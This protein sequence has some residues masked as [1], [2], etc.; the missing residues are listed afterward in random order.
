MSGEALVPGG[1]NVSNGKFIRTLTG[2]VATARF[3]EHG[4]W[5]MQRTING[6]IQ[7]PRC[8]EEKMAG[9]SLE[10]PYAKDEERKDVQLVWFDANGIMGLA[11]SKES[12]NGKWYHTHTYRANLDT[13]FTGAGTQGQWMESGI[14]WMKKTRLCDGLGFSVRKG[15]ACYFT[16]APLVPEQTSSRKIMVT[17]I[18]T[19]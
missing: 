8:H 9:C 6:P 11:G 13:F 2:G 12:Q 7:C 15:R 19:S 14:T 4:R 10:I 16:E 1:S 18:M 17:G 5:W 3:E